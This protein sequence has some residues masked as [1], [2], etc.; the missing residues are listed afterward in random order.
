METSK[1]N[2][3]N[4][5]AGMTGFVFDLDVLKRIALDCGVSDI[6]EYSELT[7]EN[8]DR[9]KMELL[10]TILQTPYSTASHTSKH[11]EWQEQIGSQSIT[12]SQREEI[13]KQLRRLAEKYN[14]NDLLEELDNMD[15]NLQ[16]ML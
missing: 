10:R 8:K 12:A 5:I 6:T 11:G 1:F 4:Y 14:E 2:I 13:K 7:Q 9:C 16:W 3:I 15:A